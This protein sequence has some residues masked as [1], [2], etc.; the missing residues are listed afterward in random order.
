MGYFIVQNVRGFTVVEFTTPSLM[1]QRELEEIGTELYR[2]VEEEDRRQVVLDFTKVQYVS[3]QAIG[4]VIN[5]HR[6][7][8][9]L[10]KS[11]LTL[12]GLGPRLQ[13]LIRITRLDR[14][15]TIKPTQAEAT[16]V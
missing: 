4:I 5:L 14:I 8:A 10:K 11:K 13:E 1:E 7:L 2:L 12:C 15:L 6:K 3:S 16:K 9:D